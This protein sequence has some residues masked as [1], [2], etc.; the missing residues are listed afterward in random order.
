MQKLQLGSVESPQ[1][2]EVGAK[3]HVSLHVFLVLDSEGASVQMLPAR[4]GYIKLMPQIAVKKINI[5]AKTENV[6]I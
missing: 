6:M 5:K 2:I 3:F 1:E 4:W